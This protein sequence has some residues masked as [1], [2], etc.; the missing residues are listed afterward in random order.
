MT[1]FAVWQLLLCMKIMI[2]YNSLNS[3]YLFIFLINIK[4]VIPQ[5][6]K[7]TIFLNPISE[8]YEFPHYLL[9]SYKWDIMEICI[10]GKSR[11]TYYLTIF[12]QL[13]YTVYIHGNLQ[14]YYRSVIPS[15][16]LLHI[17]TFLNNFSRI[18]NVDIFPKGISDLL[19]TSY[20]H[21]FK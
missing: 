12:S 3:F 2:Y 7:K 1:S 19:R 8:F 6:K 10:E 9:F 4:L 15:P 14:Y 17:S 16:H 13:A 20:S 18:R 5:D 11:I 21:S